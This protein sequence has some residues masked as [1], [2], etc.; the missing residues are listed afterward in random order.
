MSMPNE[1]KVSVASGDALDVRWFSVDERMSRLFTVKI[2]AVSRNLD[3]DFDAIIA[4]DAVFSLTT[5]EA[6]KSWR[7]LVADMDQVRVDKDGLATYTLTL[8]PRAVVLT[9]RKNYRVFQFMSELDIVKKLL[10]EWGVPHRAKANEAVHK[11]R[12]F[13]VQYGESDFT[14]ASRM[15]EDAGISFYFEDSGEETTLVLDDE[16]QQ[17]DVTHPGLP[18]FDKPDVATSHFVTKV[19]IARRVRPG[20]MTI[21]DVDYRRASAQ[22]PRQSA[23]TGLPQEGLL[24]QFD[25]E[26]GAF[27]YQRLDA[28]G[29]HT[30]VADDRGASR[31]DE[32]AGDR[33]TT[34]RLLGKRQDAQTVRFESSA[35]DLAPG[36]ILVIEDHPHASLGTSLL[37]AASHIEGNHDE[38]WRVRVDSV[39]TDVPFRP[40][41]VTPKPRIPGL[42]SATVVGAE[43]D[44]IHTDEYGRVRVHF[45][46]DRESE[47]DENSS[48]WV[49]TNQPWAGAGFGGINLPR[50]G[51]EVLVDFLDGDPDRPVVLGRVFTEHQPPPYKMPEG[52]K[53]TG[54]VGKSSPAMVT[55]A[56]ED[57]MS[58][59][60]MG[61]QLGTY[62]GVGDRQVFYAKPPEPFSPYVGDNAFLVG[63]TQ[64]QDITFIQARKDFNILVKNKWTTVV[65]NYRGTRVGGQDRL[66]IKNK[67]K[68]DIKNEQALRVR[69]NQTI[70]VGKRRVENVKKDISLKVLSNLSMSTDGTMVYKAKQPIVLESYQ[71]IRF[72]VGE[73]SISVDQSTIIVDAKSVHLNPRT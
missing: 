32:S 50:V 57:G 69:G 4:K 38:T 26:P 61:D 21:G 10:S 47:R 13:R 45:H 27:L 65:G 72:E 58:N 43:S 62:G 20:K 51:Q 66:W 9:Q 17:G 64:G 40:E 34:N 33:K 11:P 31:T 19:N 73:S 29:G 44:E 7:G 67:Q 41:P 5:S 59:S 24:E 22:Q 53:I 49:P 3:I 8:A 48:C 2:R 16:P 28:A 42:E 56:A 12:K 18:F 30:P 35:L 52:K 23:T 14:F 70:Q 37:A 39:P 54:I 15:L 25:H 36:K 55:G 46:W 63:D 71:V 68:I 1:A 60:D 6:T